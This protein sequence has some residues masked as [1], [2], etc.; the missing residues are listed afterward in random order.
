MVGVM[1]MVRVWS[2]RVKE[3]APPVAPLIVI[4]MRSCI[5]SIAQHRLGRICLYWRRGQLGR[6]LCGRRYGRRYGCLWKRE[7]RRRDD[8]ARLARIVIS[9]C[10]DDMRLVSLAIGVDIA[11][12]ARDQQDEH[13]KAAQVCAEQR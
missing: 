2:M 7:R 4:T 12:C 8:G 1:R 11:S 5:D 3:Q 10:S 13:D 6:R 9:P